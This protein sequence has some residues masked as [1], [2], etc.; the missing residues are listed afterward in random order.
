MAALNDAEPLKDSCI[1]IGSFMRSVTE[2]FILLSRCT[3]LGFQSRGSCM[4]R[5]TGAFPRATKTSSSAQQSRLLTR[6]VCHFDN[7]A[8]SCEKLLLWSYLNLKHYIYHPEAP[9]A[10]VKSS[11]PCLLKAPGMI[12]CACKDPLGGEWTDPPFGQSYV[13]HGLSGKLEHCS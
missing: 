4:A 5:S 11:L 7:T 10:W 3:T 9:K 13:E 12:L 1:S 6:C 2:N 8:I